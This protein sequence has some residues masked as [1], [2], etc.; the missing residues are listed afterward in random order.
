M[1]VS[2]AEK[3]VKEFGID[4]NNMFEFWDWVGGRYSFGRQSAFPLPVASVLIILRNY[5][6]RL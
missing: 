1:A 2:I 5:L 6:V 4:T 3:L